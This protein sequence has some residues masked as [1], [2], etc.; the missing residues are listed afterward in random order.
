MARWVDSRRSPSNIKHVQCMKTLRF[1]KFLAPQDL[2]LTLTGDFVDELARGYSQP[3][4]Q[5]LLKRCC[6]ECA[7]R[8]KFLERLQ[9]VAFEARDGH[10]AEKKI[11]RSSGAFETALD[12]MTHDTHTHNI[13]LLYTNMIKHGLSSEVAVAKQAFF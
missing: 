2:T 1:S 5:E 6:E 13:F 12:L 11:V 4:F 8:E 7:D 9:D 3:W 10:D